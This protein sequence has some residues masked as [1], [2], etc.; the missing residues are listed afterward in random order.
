[1]EKLRE[2]DRKIIDFSVEKTGEL[3][4]KISDFLT[5]FETNSILFFLIS[6]VVVFIVRI[7]SEQNMKNKYENHG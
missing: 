4:H 3:N 6:A 2:I 7:V 5:T 1:M